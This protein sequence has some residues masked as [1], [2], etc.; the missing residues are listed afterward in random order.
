MKVQ[1]RIKKLLPVQSGISRIGNN[2]KKQDFILEYFEEPTD[3]YSD[4]VL[5]SL[6]NDRIDEYSLKEG[7]EVEV[8]VRHQVKAYGERVYN[9]LLCRSV[10]KINKP[11]PATE[12]PAPQPT[13]EQQAA[14]ERLK[15][16]GEE[17]ANGQEGGSESDLPF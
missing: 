1:G 15:Q 5:L 12:Q 4:T 7:D 10:E 8:D 6:M 14:M 16:M 2:W 9:E 13:A 11:K 3:Q 17:A